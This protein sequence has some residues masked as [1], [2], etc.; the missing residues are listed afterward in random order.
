LE[1]SF[2]ILAWDLIHSGF[3]NSVLSIRAKNPDAQADALVRMPMS[4]YQFGADGIQNVVDQ[5]PAKSRKQDNELQDG[6]VC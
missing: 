1:Q 6:G 5:L 4:L 3:S 2:D